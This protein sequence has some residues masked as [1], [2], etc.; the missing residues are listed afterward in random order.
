[1]NHNKIKSILNFYSFKSGVVL[2]FLLSLFVQ[3]KE[4][5]RDSTIVYISE[6]TTIVNHNN[7]YGTKVKIINHNS[8]NPKKP[9]KSSITQKKYN[10]KLKKIANT[11]S[12][13]SPTKNTKP[14]SY[15]YKYILNSIHKIAFATV[16]TSSHFFP[17]IT[18]FP[19]HFN[20]LDSLI[21]YRKLNPEF[22]DYY[23]F[24]FF[25]TSSFFTRPPPEIFSN[26][27]N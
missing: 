2:I 4:A 5:D 22:I 6:G 21:A 9:T 20:E 18:F 12:V 16:C 11:S 19:P 10:K 1:M 8:S 27:Y 3:G 13:A 14:S 24:S 23:N 25:L 26:N 17:K 7:L 15:V